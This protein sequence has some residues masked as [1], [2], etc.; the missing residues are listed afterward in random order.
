[1]EAIEKAEAQAKLKQTR[2]ADIKRLEADRM[3]L[4]SELSKQEDVLSRLHE[5]RDFLQLLSPQEW[6]QGQQMQRVARRDARQKARNADSAM[7][8]S[9]DTNAADRPPSRPGSGRRGSMSLQRRHSFRRTDSTGLPGLPS[10]GSA[11]GG[12]RMS[13][14][15]RRRNSHLSLADAADLDALRQ[16]AAA[17][18]ER[19]E[20]EE[21][22]EYPPQLY[23]TAPGQVLEMFGK[24]EAENL[25]LIQNGQ[26]SAEGLQDLQDRVRGEQARMTAELDEAEAATRS[27]RDQIQAERDRMALCK[28]S[29]RFVTEAQ[30]QQS[31]GKS[32]GKSIGKQHE[33]LSQAVAGEDKATADPEL[34]LLDRR[35]AE[36]YRLC[37]GENDANIGTVQMLTNL[38]T[39]LEELFERM[40]RMPAAALARAEK[41]KEKG[42]RLRL[43]EEKLEAQQAHQEMR[44][45]KAQERS[46]QAPKKPVGPSPFPLPGSDLYPLVS[47]IATA[48]LLLLGYC[49]TGFRSRCCTA[50]AASTAAS[51]P[52]SRLARSICTA[53]LLRHCPHTSPEHTW[54]ALTLHYSSPAVSWCTGRSHRNARSE[55]QKRSRRRRRR[56]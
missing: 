48:A 26:E 3:A 22:E 20:R 21:E 23:F 31:G 11:G 49:M 40:E 12:R 4:N 16:R 39:L 35:V 41:A 15:L 54:H 53:P 30:Q 7:R 43:R 10:Q 5:Y 2:V 47:H 25:S 14:T 29:I 28:R 51:T 8:G 9:C 18:M 27:L 37:I 32:K 46:Q 17:E 36:A 56:R 19:E 44:M 52:S 6:L 45:R 24:L 38:E 42:R 13:G 50:G 1:V 34:Q 55:R 33:S